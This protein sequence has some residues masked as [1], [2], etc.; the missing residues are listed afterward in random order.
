MLQYT[1]NQ[2][3]QTVT[4]GAGYTAGSG[5][6]TL[7]GGD[8]A[9]LPAS[10]NFWI[11]QTQLSIPS[12]SA[13]LNILK[14]TARSGDTLTVVGGQDGTTDQNIA[15]GTEMAWVLSAS[16]LTELIAAPGYEFPVW[17][18]YTIPFGSL[19]A[20]ALTQTITLF[21]LPARAKLIGVT[22]KHSAQFTAAGL[23]SLNLTLGSSVDPQRYAGAL[24]ISTAVSD[25][26]FYDAGYYNSQTM[27]A[28]AVNA[29][30]T[31]VG[32]NLNTLAAGSVDIWIGWV[33]LP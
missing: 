25:T 3:L 27:A 15:N 33:Q 29:V 26:N 11:R 12:Q 6:M 24:N 30:F 32:A 5:T 9:K 16:A 17:V 13:L 23:T 14:V 4:L 19:T 31:A 2:Y 22:L 20:A 8:G 28:D 1:G 7:T 10:G 18:K 21:T